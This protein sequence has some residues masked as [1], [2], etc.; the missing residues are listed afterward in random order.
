MPREGPSAGFD[1]VPVCGFCIE[2]L[3]ST[4]FFARLDIV[5]DNEMQSVTAGGR[6]YLRNLSLA[7]LKRY[8]DAYNIKADDVLEK[9]DLIEKIIAIRVCT[10]PNNIAY[11]FE[12]PCS[13]ENGCLPYANEVIQLC[14][15]R[16]IA[17]TQFRFIELLQEALSSQ[18][19]NW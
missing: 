16:C 3:T 6:A 18:R 9:D 19:S 14:F 12:N 10:S 13:Q 11:V 2:N 7:R 1:P 15:F 17:S 5:F 8:V 4:S